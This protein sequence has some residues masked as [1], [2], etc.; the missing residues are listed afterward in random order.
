MPAKQPLPPRTLTILFTLA[1]LEGLGCLTALLRIPA[2]PAGAILFG[3]SAARL[4]LAA[5]I[6]LGTLLAAL[7][8]F[9]QSTS[10]Y[11]Q[12]A[13]AEALVAP[14]AF[15]TLLAGFLA[16]LAFCSLWPFADT[17]LLATFRRALPVA[18]FATLIC[19]QLLSVR[20]WYRRSLSEQRI[21]LIGLA[22]VLV[23]FFVTASGHYSQV[24]REYWLSDQEAM[25]NF[26]RALEA[27]GFKDLGTRDFM[28]GFPVLASPFVDTSMD[29]RGLYAEGKTFN[30]GLS[31]VLL[32][33]VHLIARRY[34]DLLVS[35]LF[36]GI[37]GLTLFIYKAPY[38]QPELLYYF[39]SFAA[40]VLM[41]QLLRRPNWLG[42]IGA[43]LLLAAAQY[44]KASVLPAVALF[45]VAMLAQGAYLLWI[46]KEQLQTASRYAGVLLIALLAFLLPLAPYLAE[47][48]ATY[49]SY[50]YNVNSTY[51]LWFDS[52]GEAKASEQVFHYTEGVPD[53]PKDQL[54]SLQNYLRSHDAGDIAQRFAAGFAN[55]A[56]NWLNTF[57]LV[58]FPLVFTL[59]LGVLIY[60]RWAAVKQFV[61]RQPVFT[62]FVF[63]YFI[64]YTALFAW[65]G[66]I[67]DYSDRRFTYGLYLPLLFCAF[68]GLRYLSQ[69]QNRKQKK[70]GWLP[71]F[72]GSAAVLLA[73][74]LLFHLPYQ[75]LEFHWFGK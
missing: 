67:A 35:A 58:S 34:F 44:T 60:Q 51:F 69:S 74:D 37:A 10:K 38:F 3:F 73:A 71:A 68:L 32:A 21:G 54:P 49:G 33:G 11:W 20:L 46:K 41:L 13:F 75:F 9:L 72:Y 12:V 23:L 56:G 24:N 4:A 7:A 29:Q 15:W 31:L 53:V 62:A 6:G 14:W 8:A 59:A 52:W 61:T 26:V 47:S 2:D 45:A 25:L 39:L 43:G 27:S 18:L 17:A 19:G 5:I 30:I 57:A 64:G 36:T 48:K 66:P 1:S 55:Q 40:F 70:A 63:L 22:I 42:A 65:Y 16:G 28:P 50:F